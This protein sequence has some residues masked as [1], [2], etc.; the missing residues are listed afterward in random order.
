M[1]LKILYMFLGEA[2]VK[3]L[4]I[5]TI[6]LCGFPTSIIAILMNLLKK[7]HRKCGIVCYRRYPKSKFHPS[8]PQ[9]FYL[10][11]SDEGF[12]R[13]IRSR[14]RQLTLYHSLPYAASL[15]INNVT[16]TPLHGISPIS[17]TTALGCTWSVDPIHAT[18]I[19]KCSNV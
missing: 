5:T 4:F 10:R 15:G 2:A 14:T 19:Y 6:F 18:L 13:P 3:L 1:Q 7:E 11:N 12:L 8:F 16:P 9:V 17:A